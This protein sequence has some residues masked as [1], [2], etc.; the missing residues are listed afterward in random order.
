MS[1]V[2]MQYFHSAIFTLED[3][4][5]YKTKSCKSSYSKQFVISHLEGVNGPH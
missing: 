1:L 4:I 3:K 2:F 5:I